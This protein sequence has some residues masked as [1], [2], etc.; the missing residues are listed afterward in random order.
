MHVMT[1]CEAAI[2]NGLGMVR[3]PLRP[4]WRPFWLRCTDVTSVLV[5]KY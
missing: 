5:E 4:L 1:Q 2:D 3:R